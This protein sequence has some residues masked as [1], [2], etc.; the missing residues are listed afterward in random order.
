MRKLGRLAES[1]IRV[2]V[3]SLQRRLG[4]LER[5]G[6][7]R[8]NIGRADLD[9]GAQSFGRVAGGVLSLAGILLVGQGL[10]T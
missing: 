4:R 7:G 10:V 1:A 2:I 8:T 5:F 9:R 3:D 6:I